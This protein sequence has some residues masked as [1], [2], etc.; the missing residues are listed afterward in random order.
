MRI[1]LK[2]DSLHVLLDHPI[3]LWILHEIPKQAD[4]TDAK[5][6]NQRLY[7]SPFSPDQDSHGSTVEDWEEII[8]P[9]LKEEFQAAVK[10]VVHD[11]RRTR[12]L[13][14]AENAASRK[15]DD[16]EFDDE[17]TEL[18]TAD[19]QE[20]EEPLPDA[21]LIEIPHEHAQEWYSAMNQ[22]RLVMVE[23]QLMIDPNGKV[24]GP[25]ELQMCYEL[26]TYLQQLLIELVLDR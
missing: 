9:E 19:D 15:S 12:K 7:P 26:Y 21:Y 20:Q 24:H 2:E 25:A 18:D 4:P 14:Q 17:L 16:G 10:T 5:E 1:Q 23:K 6:A 3:E 11:L 13:S 8:Y 22:A